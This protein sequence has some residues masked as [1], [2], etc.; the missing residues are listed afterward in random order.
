[1]VTQ[2]I[3]V[4]TSFEKIFVVECDARNIEVGAILS[5]EGRPVVFFSERLNEAK[6]MHSAYNLELYALEQSLKKWR[7][8]LLPKDFMSSEITKP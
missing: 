7:H 8:Y 4:L 5:Q 3:L 1:M 6:N 2:P